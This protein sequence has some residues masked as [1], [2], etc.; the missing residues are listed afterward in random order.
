MPIFKI[1]K[2]KLEPISEEKID[3]ERDIQKLTEQNLETVLG[4]KFICSEFQLNN[5]RIDT[6][7]FDS[8]S[9]SFVIIEFKKDRSYSVIDQGYAYLGL[10]LNSK[11]DFILEYNE[12]MSDNLR[13]EDVDWSQSRVYF[14]SNQFTTYQQ[15]A[16]HFND[17]PIELWEAKI[18]NNETVLFNQVKSPDSNESIKTITKNKTVETVSRE[19][20]KYSVEDHLRGKPRVILAIFD[21]FRQRITGLGDNVTEFAKKH[22]IAYKNPRIN[23]V[24]F[25]LY[26]SKLHID[27]II[28][29]EKVSDP[30]NLLKKYPQSYGYAKNLKYF[31]VLKGDDYNYA[32]ELISQAY[33]F[34]NGRWE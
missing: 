16:L 29:D 12:K 1:N 2:S 34:N 32:M 4:L 5:L 26:K 18:F 14:V 15:K 7:A 11:A 24:T 20:K 19:V 17:M 25:H 33:K 6:L 13:R 27:I 23:F 3:L 9:K 10:M 22:Y 8:E 30:R 21:G 31:E 28:G